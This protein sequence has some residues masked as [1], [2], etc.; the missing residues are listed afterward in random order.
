[1]AAIRVAVLTISDGVAQGTRADR[2]GPCIAEWVTQRSYELVAH[3]V[4]PDEVAAISERLIALAE[5]G[6]DVV[7]TT[8]GTGLTA[9]DVTPEATA[10]IVTR[11]VP[12]IAEALRAQGAAQTPY[13]WISRGV[14]GVRGSTLIVNLP[15][16]EA[17]VRDGL[18]LLEKLVEHAVQ[19]L[20]GIQTD[21]H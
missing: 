16:S 21:K 1:V 18:Q 14:A 15:G 4:V 20:R 17:A 3:D 6:C 7:I 10:A 9:R 19:L 13:S 2:S 5:R 8:G 11:V 12:G